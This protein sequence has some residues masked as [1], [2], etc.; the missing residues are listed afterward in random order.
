MPTGYTAGVQSGEITEFKEFALTCARAFGA[1][2]SLRDEP[3]DNPIP[4]EFEPSDYH[5]KQLVEAEAE[6]RRLL[7]MT[8]ADYAR[9]AQADYDNAVDSYNERIARRQV[10]AERYTA[11]LKQA[12]AW[13]PP[14]PEHDELR[15]FMIQ[16]LTESINFDCR[17]SWDKPPEPVGTETWRRDA[18]AKVAKNIEY[19]TEQHAKEVKRAKDRTE[20]VRALRESLK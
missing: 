14:T 17:E 10:E 7:T 3:L 12:E 4:E 1:C 16:Q 9:A 19:H 18:I 13:E 8:E 11:M 2:V 6:M 5:R 20:W 15:K